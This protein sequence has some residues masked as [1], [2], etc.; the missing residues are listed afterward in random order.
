MSGARRYQVEPGGALKE[1]D[2]HNAVFKTPRGRRSI[3]AIVLLV[4]SATSVWAF[5]CP[6]PNH[7]ASDE[8]TARQIFTEAVKKEDSAP[9]RAL[10]ELECAEEL[11]PRPVIALR[12]GSLAEKSK[13]WER[14][15]NAYDRYLRLSGKSAPDR[16]RMKER[17]RVLRERAIIAE[18]DKAREPTGT[19]T[20]DQEELEESTFS[21]MP[22][23]ILIGS[24]AALAIAGSAFLVS[25]S[26]KSSG[27]HNVSAG[28]NTAWKSA[29]G[30]ERYDSAK[31]DQIIGFIG[32]GLG[33]LAGGAGTYLMIRPLDQGVAARYAI[34]F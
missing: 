11:W 30:E 15:A 28:S 20:E 34:Q 29:D 23:W 16:A 9:A 3:R 14:A 31:R 22:A 2:E 7:D 18:R 4:F 5:E 25:A 24:G 12:I 10:A 6:K 17:I 27:V 33:L 21:N 1:F 26:Q 32:L 13:D 8:A 19:K